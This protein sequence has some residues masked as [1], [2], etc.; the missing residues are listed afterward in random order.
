MSV[1]APANTPTFP[2]P[3]HPPPFRRPVIVWEGTLRDSKFQSS[4]GMAVQSPHKSVT[5][6][7][8]RSRVHHSLW[9]GLQSFG[10][11][12]RLSAPARQRKQRGPALGGPCPS[13]AGR[14]QAI[15]ASEP[16]PRDRYADDPLRAPSSGVFP[17]MKCPRERVNSRQPGPGKW[18][19]SRMVWQGLAT[20][21]PSVELL[22]C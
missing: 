1:I 20:G 2:R 9:A 12:L 7:S 15:T 8:K 5:E 17:R 14:G 3:R 13:R 16:T 21:K 4:T 19:T 11:P 18:G 10:S 22:N 6:G